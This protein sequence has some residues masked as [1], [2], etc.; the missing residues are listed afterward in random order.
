[1]KHR[2]ICLSTLLFLI[3]VF[4]GHAQQNDFPKLTGLYIGQKLPGRVPEIFAP[5]IITFPEDK[6]F[7]F[8]P[9]PGPCSES[10]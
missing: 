4:S 7:L 1:M 5:G 6:S 9:E 10:A 2:V 8:R 3:V